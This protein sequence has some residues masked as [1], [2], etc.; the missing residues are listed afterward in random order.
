MELV[1]VIH[2][3]LDCRYEELLTL[4]NC[5]YDKPWYETRGV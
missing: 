1:H 4:A 3:C 5:K 2:G